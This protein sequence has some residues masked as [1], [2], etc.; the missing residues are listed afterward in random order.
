MLAAGCWWP[1]GLHSVY[2]AKAPELA[3]KSIRDSPP[4]TCSTSTSLRAR[5]DLLPALGMIR[6]SARSDRKPRARSITLRASLANVGALA[7][8]R[9]LLTGE[10]FRQLKPLFV[11]RRPAQFRARVLPVGRRCFS[12]ASC[13]STLWWSLRGFRGDQT[14]LPAVLLL[15]GVGPDPHD[16]PARSGA[17]QP[18][19]RRFRAGRGG[20]LRAAGRAEPARL[21]AALRQAELRAAAGQLRALR[22][23]HPVRITARARA[24]PRSTCSDSSRWRSSACCWCFFLAG[25]FAQPLGRAAARARNAPVGWRALTRRFDIPPLEYTVAGAGVA[26]RSRWCS[27]FCKRTWARRWC[28]PA[29]SWCST[30]SRAAARWCRWPGWRWCWPGF[31]VGL[32][33]GRAAHRGRARLHVA[34]ALGQPG[35]RRRSTGAL[36]V[37]LRH[38]RRVRHGHRAGR[39]ATRAGRAHRPDPLGAGRRVGLRRRGRGVRAVRAVIV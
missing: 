38:R 12:P 2:Q 26:W 23:A 39:S 35:P 4:N 31:V 6:R 19:V 14:L 11:V 9:G 36:A 13:W 3:A 22:A 28:S 15:T 34:F 7:R 37:G 27:S 24:T 30:A 17:R 33:H 5:E 18:A 21:R 25:Y 8:I 32:R 1:S 10:Q 29:C 20:R 16:Q